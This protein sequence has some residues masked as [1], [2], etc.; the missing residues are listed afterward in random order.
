MFGEKFCTHQNDGRKPDK[1]TKQAQ[2]YFYHLTPVPIAIYRHIKPRDLKKG[3][4]V[5]KIDKMDF[6]NQE[7]KQIS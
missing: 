5:R 2:H 3:V 4:A 1:Q 6:G 7:R